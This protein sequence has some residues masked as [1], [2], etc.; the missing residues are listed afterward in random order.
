MNWYVPKKPEKSINGKFYCPICKIT[1]M[2]RTRTCLVCGQTLDWNAVDAEESEEL[3]EEPE[4]QSEQV[5]C[6]LV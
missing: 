2:T 5:Y 1:L 4:N 6:K 3:Y